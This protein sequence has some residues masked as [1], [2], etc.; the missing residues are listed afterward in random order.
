MT[1]IAYSKEY[2]VVG[3]SALLLRNKRHCEGALV[4]ARS[5][6]LQRHGDCFAAKVQERRLAMTRRFCLL[7]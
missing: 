3:E 2:D 4:L 1:G 5:N 7:A 6:P